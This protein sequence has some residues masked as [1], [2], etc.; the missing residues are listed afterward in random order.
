LVHGAGEKW[1]NS[2][3]MPSKRFCQYC[4]MGMIICNR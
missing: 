2:A 1:I 3:F 4:H